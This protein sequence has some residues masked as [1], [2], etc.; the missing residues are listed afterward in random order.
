MRTR[1]V[2]YSSLVIAFLFVGGLGCRGGSKEAKAAAK[3]VTLE[4]WS[5]AHDSR[6][7]E[8]LLAKY[9]KTHEH[10]RI[11]YRRFRPEEFEQQ[12]L[13]AL[14]EDRGPDIISLN[15]TWI[16]KYQTKLLP[17]PPTVQVA[18]VFTQKGA[19][20][21]EQIAEIGTTPLPSPLQME[22]IFVPAVVRDVVRAD[23]K[24]KP[25]IL[26]LPLALDTMVLFYNQDLLDQAGVPQAPSTWAELQEAVVAATR[27]DSDGSIAQAGGA[28]GTGKNVD[29]G[30]D[31]VTALMLQNGAT[32]ADGL[33]R[34]VFNL[35]P[36]GQR[37]ESSPGIEALRFY[38][39]FGN[40]T[41]Q[42]YTWNAQMEPSLDAFGRG[43]ATFFFGYAYHIPLL[44]ARAPKL[45]YRI[46]QIPQLHPEKPQNVA[47]YWVESVSKKTKNPNEAWDVVNFLTRA[48]QADVYTERTRRPTALRASVD[49]QSQNPD[50]APF[51]AQV[52]SAR[53]W[54]RGRNP[55]AADAALVEMIDFIH[56]NRALEESGDLFDTAVNRAASKVNQS[57]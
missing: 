52:L 8:E 3:P 27:Y 37:A 25:Q 36:E 44:K 11:R 54:Y 45:N 47:N 31:I 32:M 38:T 1:W 23:D 19:V 29:R 50:L 49:K 2:L 17:A 26:G 6:L 22:R 41:K 42:V 57:L 55:A 39:D 53:S 7:I 34:A 43:K 51:A 12:L 46:L 40:P 14:A 5:T 20:R 21:T 16:G 9:R 4:Y 28:F 13:E 33:G 18:R 48:E 15:N 10:I 35:I 56:D 30:A 24:G